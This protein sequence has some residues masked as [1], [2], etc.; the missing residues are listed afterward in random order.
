MAIRRFSSLLC[1]LCICSTGVGFAQTVPFWNQGSGYASGPATMMQ[2]GGYAPPQYAPAGYYGPPQPM[3]TA[4]FEPPLPGSREA[5][6]NEMVYPDY[7]GTSNEPEEREL[8]RFLKYAFDRSWIRLEYLNWN[9]E[10]PGNVVVGQD[11]ILDFFGNTTDPRQL[12][13]IFDNST[14]FL[15]G[16]GFAPDLSQVSFNDNSG[17]RGTFGRE[18]EWGTFVMD[19]WGIQSASETV[20]LTS[21]LQA[22]QPFFYFTTPLKVDHQ[23]SNFALLADAS[24]AVQVKTGIWGTNIEGRINTG[25][26]PTGMNVQ[27]VVG[28]NFTQVHSKMHLITGYNNQGTEPLLISSLRSDVQNNLFGPTL[29]L[30]A[31]FNISRLSFGI[32]PKV[33]LTTARVRRVTATDDLAELGDT[34]SAK[35]TDYRFAPI[36]SL[37]A[38]AKLRV[39][40]SI[41]L[42]ASWDGM[43]FSRVGKAPSS[44]DYNDNL[45][46]PFTDI[47][48]RNNLN[49]LTVSGISAGAEILLY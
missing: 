31:N 45:S 21:T 44:I 28:L 10:D 27:T 25:Q 3:M 2:G 40:D 4:N 11:P 35:D 14:G 26:W 20:D 9:V 48:P 8:E 32:I 13:D 18:D 33:A 36:L 23:L 24:Y 7:Y 47:R 37:N 5:L 43:W 34:F 46:T 12:D 16:E 30:N 29:G 17:I 22:N 19:F 1:V 38:Y 49:S 6:V 41:S 42:F 39:T 15:I